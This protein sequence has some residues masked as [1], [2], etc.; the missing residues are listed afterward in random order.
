MAFKRPFEN[1]AFSLVYTGG[2]LPNIMTLVV[3]LGIVKVCTGG[4]Q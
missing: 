2:H 1:E 4:L 3:T